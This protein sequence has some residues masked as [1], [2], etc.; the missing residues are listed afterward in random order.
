MSFWIVESDGV[1]HVRRY[2]LQQLQPLAAHRRLEIGEPGDVASRTREARGETCADRIADRG[3]DD[4]NLEA[5]LPERCHRRS[6]L[7]HDDV[8]RKPAQLFGKNKQPAGIAG[9]PGHACPMKSVRRFLA[10]ES[11]STVIE[12]GL[13]AA[14]ISLAIIAAVNGLGAKLNTKFTSVNSL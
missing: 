12:H 7:G 1:R 6:A 2:L 4:W 14:D 11:D 5:F 13:I 3:E 9:A 8:Q 10:D